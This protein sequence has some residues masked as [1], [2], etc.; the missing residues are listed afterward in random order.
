MTSILNNVKMIGQ[1]EAPGGSFARLQITGE[2]LFRGDVSCER[3]KVMGKVKINGDLT[4]KLVKFTGEMKV[5]G[6]LSVGNTRGLGELT[7]GRDFRG[8]DVRL[9]GRLEADGSIEADKLDIRGAF[10][11]KAIVNAE[12]VTLFMYGPSTAKEIVGGVVSI[13]KSRGALWN[14]LFRK[15]LHAAL[16]TNLI[17]GDD[18]YVEYATVDVIRGN[19]VKIGPGCHIGRVEYRSTYIKHA[20]S[21]VEIEQKI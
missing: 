13:K 7:V 8:E 14:S 2:T 11:T 4:S 9:T 3:F 19:S 5:D 16:R 20:K 15:E 17:E 21:N 6:S 10:D 12:R 18:I 1:S